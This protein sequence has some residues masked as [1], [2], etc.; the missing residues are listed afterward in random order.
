MSRG[1]PDSENEN[2]REF[3]W[4]SE[5][6]WILR[7]FMKFHK[8]SLFRVQT[9][10]NPPN[11]IRPWSISE[12]GAKSRIFLK[13]HEI[14]W[15]FMNFRFYVKM[16]N[17]QNFHEISPFRA[18]PGLKTCVIFHFFEKLKNVSQKLKTFQ[19]F[20]FPIKVKF[21]KFLEFPLFSFLRLSRSNKGYLGVLSVTFSQNLTFS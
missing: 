3:H 7:N 5:I 17:F 19:L 16:Q 9:P 2:F 8:F 13:F 6:S 1:F 21:H 18:L 4:K 10:Q 14:S 12:G 11:S 20:R 15:N